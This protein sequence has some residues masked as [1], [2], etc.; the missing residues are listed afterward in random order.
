MEMV[1]TAIAGTSQ[2]KISSMA[3]GIKN[4]CSKLLFIY[5]EINRIKKILE[6]KNES[7]TYRQLKRKNLLGVSQYLLDA[8][9]R[10]V[11][12]FYLLNSKEREALINNA[13]TWSIQVIDKALSLGTEVLTYV[14]NLNI[15]PTV[16]YLEEVAKELNI[17]QKKVKN[18]E[19]LLSKIA[20]HYGLKREAKEHLI[21]EL[22]NVTVGG[23]LDYFE[24]KGFD[25][26]GLQ[27]L[28]NSTAEVEEKISTV[29]FVNKIDRSK[30]MA[31][32]L[33][34]IENKSQQDLMYFNICWLKA[35]EECKGTAISS[36]DFAKKIA[37]VSI[38]ESKARGRGT[39]GVLEAEVAGEEIK[40]WF[41]DKRELGYIMGTDIAL[42]LDPKNVMDYTRQGIEKSN[43]PRSVLQ[44]QEKTSE[45]S[46]HMEN[47]ANGAKVLDRKRQKELEVV[48]AAERGVIHK[49][50]DLGEDLAKGRG[51][52]GIKVVG[53]GIQ[54]GAATAALL[55][56]LEPSHAKK[57]LA[58][59]EKIE[60]LK[61]NTDAVTTKKQELEKDVVN[62]RI[63]GLERQV[64][65]V[66][67][68]KQELEKDVVSKKIEGL[69]RQVEVV[70]SK[71]QELE[72]MTNGSIS[73]VAPTNAVKRQ[74]DTNKAV[75]A[76]KEEY[77]PSK[78]LADYIELSSR[79][80]VDRTLANQHLEK[81]T[82]QD[83]EWTLNAYKKYLE[84]HESATVKKAVAKD[85]LDE[86]TVKL[87]GTKQIRIEDGK[88]NLEDKQ[89]FLE[90]VTK[91]NS[92]EHMFEEMP[93][94]GCISQ[95]YLQVMALAKIAEKYEKLNDK[96]RASYYQEIEKNKAVNPKNYNIDLDEHP[97][98]DK[99]MSR[100]HKKAQK[101]LAQYPHLIDVVEQK[102]P[103]DPQKQ[104]SSSAPVSQSSS[105]STPTPLKE[106]V[107]SDPSVE[108]TE[109]QSDLPPQGSE[110]TSN[111]SIDNSS[112]EKQNNR[113]FASKTV[114]S[115][116]VEERQEQGVK[117]RSESDIFEYQFKELEILN[118]R[119]GA[120]AN[121]EK[122]LQL[123]DLEDYPSFDQKVEYLNRAVDQIQQRLTEIES[124]I[125]KQKAIQ[126]KIGQT[127]D[128]TTTIE[129]DIAS[130]SQSDN[131]V[132][133]IKAKSETVEKKLSAKDSEAENADRE[134]IALDYAGEIKKL[135]FFRQKEKIQ[136]L[137]ENEYIKTGFID[138][139]QM[140]A[141]LSE[142]MSSLMVRVTKDNETCFKADVPVGNNSQQE[143][144][145]SV[146]KIPSET[147]KNYVSRSREYFADPVKAKSSP[148]QTKQVETKK[149]Q[150]LE[151]A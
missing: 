34:L 102:T 71:K 72:Q 54:A 58:I 25:V 96:D 112:T 126:Q 1:A 134:L 6:G 119:V 80:S 40:I 130:I 141:G 128:R 124:H 3:I 41:K 59:S 16:N 73:P 105:T 17:K 125:D 90:Q 120:L 133:T 116:K 60:S 30:N 28:I 92:Y 69:E 77:L 83:L 135:F 2:L 12:K 48:I 122:V 109:N 67:S 147:M 103:Y 85:G 142:G 65:V 11:P 136:S 108:S 115:T 10:I 127:M 138:G 27:L 45:K 95:T 89:K 88:V 78:A 121:E 18:N 137:K 79:Y 49:T 39:S 129:S 99:E 9:E 101:Y 22:K 100:Y 97:E 31:A 64:E 74:S 61:Q 21:R 143:T 145:V 36:T 106:V 111:N 70:E 57:L 56:A 43:S 7:L 140:D 150:Q 47:V 75:R 84:N 52:S 91:A 5:S 20:G 29:E 132:N 110:V 4:K 82:A 151:M 51:L 149:R 14:L 146:N 107:S 68:K 42:S 62:K 98:P 148:T 53:L 32:P 63:E 104:Q 66:E 86:A 114:P 26:G 81:I 38:E 94:M 117:L 15:K 93:K 23:I 144:V 50:E 8:A 113:P 87:L 55:K 13:G 24:E 123:E 131:L 139:Y 76:K 44:Q 19:E 37:S 35:K 46:T 33:N 118:R